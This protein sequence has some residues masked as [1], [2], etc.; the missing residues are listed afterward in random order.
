MD[1]TLG[2]ATARQG[3][4]VKG[5]LRVGSMADGSPIRLPVLIASGKADGPT[6]W[7]QACIHGEEFG[8]AA[9][10]IHFMENLNLDELR[11]TLIGIP[12]ANP[13]SFNI[14]SRVSSLDGHN[15]NRIFPGDPAG[16]FSLQLAAVLGAELARHADYLIDLHSGGIGAE[17]PF[18][19]IYKDDGTETAV[20][21]KE[22]AKRIGCDVLWR[23]IGEAGLGGTVT[24]E[25]NRAG[26]PSI[27]VE[28]GGGTFTPQHLAD[29]STSIRGFLQALEMLP[30]EAPIQ[31]RYTIV[32]EGAFLHNREGG[33]FI[34]ECQAG[35]FLPE[36]GLIGRLINLHGETVEEI[37]SPYDQAYIAALRLPY[38][39]THAG[40]I[41]A[42]AIPTESYETL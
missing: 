8:G 9:S 26:I 31:E 7:V 42:E 28:V 3:E 35:D 37:R 16:S 36:G 30:G 17:V 23:T 11:G 14:H 20:R 32:S 39:P 19:V 4:L 13:P 12:V 34:Q 41:V 24:A 1:I 22:L 33:L 2:T 21:A 5:E 6:V 38:W 10:I 27:T 18:Y 40:D 29:Y 25:A 15:L